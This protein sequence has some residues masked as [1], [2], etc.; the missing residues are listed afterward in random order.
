MSLRLSPAADTAFF[1]G[2]K[3]TGPFDGMQAEK[4][5]VPFADTT[6]VKPPDSVTD[7][8]AICYRTPFLQAGS[9]GC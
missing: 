7:D 6:L 5:R 4:V 1:G 9:A 2:P 8:K 3:Q